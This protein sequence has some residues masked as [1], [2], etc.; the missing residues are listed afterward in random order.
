M[1]A[2]LLV[3][4]VAAA[5]TYLLSGVAGQVARRVG[6]V[7]AVRDRDVHV[8][9]K[10]RL[11]G[12]A[13]LCGVA[14]AFLVASRLPFLGQNFTQDSDARAVLWGSLV[15]TAVGT[16]DDIIG[17]DA[18]TKFAGQV[19]A[20]GIVVIEGVRLYWVALPGH[21][22]SL[23][24]SI[25]AIVTTLLIVA[26]T[27]AVNFIDGLDGLAAGVVAIGA[28]AFFGWCYLLAVQHHTDRAST[29]GLIAAALTGA[30]VGFLPHNLHPSR[31]IMGDSGALLLGF[32]MSTSAL[33]LTGQLDPASLVSVD[34]S[35]QVRGSET[36][37]PTLLPLL[38]PIAVVAVPFAELLLSV[39]RRTLRGRS[40]FSPDKKHLHHRLLELGHSHRRATLVMWIWAAVLSYG[41]LA[42]GLHGTS[43][44]IGL[45]LGVLVLAIALTV[46]LPD[47][48]HRRWQAGRHR[49]RHRLAPAPGIRSTPLPAVRTGARLTATT[50]VPAD[51]LLSADGPVMR[52]VAG[53]Q[54]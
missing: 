9:P 52:P 42:I 17:L 21:T 53:H 54:P 48:I 30:C 20:A 43:D 3:L 29:A 34:A 51:D 18:V 33:T 46:A 14:A 49:R 27:N 1:R 50:S 8:V 15:I 12:L 13:I 26:T 35:G 22:F 38:L 5:T 36:L 47:R 44:V 45:V 2:Y 6:A 31:I 28:S 32:L 25:V 7:P 24:P 40:P 39:L 4:F 11:G 37:L 23:S 19:L 16:V 10:P 41:V